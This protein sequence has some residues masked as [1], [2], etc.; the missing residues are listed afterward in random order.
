[1]NIHKISKKLIIYMTIL[2]EIGINPIWIERNKLSNN[3]NKKIINLI[4]FKSNNCFDK[5]KY[6]IFTNKILLIL[7]KDINKINITRYLFI[8]HD[9]HIK[10]EEELFNNILHAFNIRKKITLKFN[11][12][13]LNKY[14]THYHPSIL[15]FMGKEIELQLINIKIF[16]KII[17]N[18]NKQIIKIKNKKNTI[19]NAYPGDLYHIK[20]I[21][22]LITHEISYLLNNPYKKY[23]L[24]NDFCLL[25]N[26]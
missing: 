5:K 7:C 12:I 23:K 24:W 3:N 1:M 4:S 11:L 19:L 18:K 9:F 26:L 22:I 10:E 25:K 14:I 17:E 15:I 21:L 2:N 20:N 16:E 8:M 13:E 6:K